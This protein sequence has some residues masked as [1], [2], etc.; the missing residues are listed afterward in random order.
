MKK[1]KKSGGVKHR[2]QKGNGQAR[3]KT[4]QHILSDGSDRLSR[5]HEAS[6]REPGARHSATRRKP[7]RDSEEQKRML[8]D[9]KQSEL[10]ARRVAAE[11]RRREEDLQR[12][13]TTRVVQ[14]ISAAF[15]AV[16]V[17]ILAWY[18]A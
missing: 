5:S 4:E 8:W 18:V 10:E 14:G 3:L 1:P 17:S 7:Q 15:L 12:R 6:P 9:R 2:R 13:R 11:S 16:L